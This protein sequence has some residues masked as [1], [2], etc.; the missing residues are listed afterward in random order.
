MIKQIDLKFGKNIQSTPLSFEPA[1]IN[2]IVGPNNSGKSLLLRELDHYFSGDTSHFEYKIL[3]YIN[4]PILSELEA[5][6]LISTI[7]LEKIIGEAPG[8]DYFSFIHNNQRTQI[9]KSS[10]INQL[11]SS[12]NIHEKVKYFMSNKKLYL[13]GETRLT[14][15]SPVGYDLVSNNNPS[16]ISK[17]IIDDNKFC[18]LETQVFSAFQKYPVI[19][20][21]N[22]GLASIVLSNT[23]IPNELKLS[24]KQE[25][26]EF[27][28]DCLDE[29]NLSDGI[30]AYI[31]IMLEVSAGNPEILIIDEPEAFLHPPLAK[32]LGNVLSHSAQIENKKLFIAT[33]SAQFIMGCIESG[34]QINILRFTYQNEIP[35]VRLLDKESLTE[36][37]QDP[38]MRSSNVIESLF[39]KSVVVT[40]S[41]SDRAF[42]QEINNRLSQ[43]KPE[44]HINDTLFL[45]AQNKQTVGRIV[46]PLRDLGIPAVSIIDLDFVKDG[47]NVFSKYLSSCNIPNSSISGHSQTKTTIKSFF[48]DNLDKNEPLKSKGLEYLS[49]GELETARNLLDQLNLYGLFPVPIGELESWLK[50]VPAYGHGN[51]KV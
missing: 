23:K 21:N 5:E 10:A 14:R 8:D 1:S 16:P 34:V 48:P 12:D 44:W 22:G 42:Y 18:T 38:L 49:N 29:N 45:N 27:Y 28:A 15:L 4:F 25:S 37:M 20:L 26:L 41:D 2:I 50:D 24:I 46:K 11:T 43:F 31:G 30:K 7:S 32:T 51:G 47:G 19:K 33:H 40:E 35:T 6:E 36:L 9:Y 39:F 13:N 3:K 17:L